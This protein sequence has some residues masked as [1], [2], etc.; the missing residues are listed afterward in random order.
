[1]ARWAARQGRQGKKINRKKSHHTK[2]SIQGDGA[3]AGPVAPRGKGAAMARVIVFGS[4][5][6]DLSMVCGRMPR[7]GETVLGSGF[8]TNPGGKGANQ[9]V[10]A[11]R[12]GATTLMIGRVGDDAF[13]QR[14]TDGL[15]LSGVDCAEVQTESGYAT[16]TAMIVRSEGQNRIIVDPGANHALDAAAA[17]QILQKL[18]QPGDVLLTQLECDLDATFAVIDLA[19]QMGLYTILN[20]APAHELPDSVYGALDLLCVNETEC[21]SLCG[22]YPADRWRAREA[23]DCFTQHGVRNTVI[24]LGKKGSVTLADRRV[25][26]VPAYKVP[27]V[28]STGA[29]DAYLGVLAGRLCDGSSLIEGMRYATAASALAVQ[30]AGAQQSMPTQAQIQEFI[31]VHGLDA[32]EDAAQKEAW[33]QKNLLDDSAQGDDDQS[34]QS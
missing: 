10:A 19:H 23:L 1:M 34:A 22:V 30:K 32:Q 7:A 25:V 12:S 11:A 24:T 33:E 27:A 31:D 14:L 13:G 9:A 21:D 28:D 18:A 29:G 15:L 17:R 6:M 4:L 5:N 3:Q 8:F 2:E 26:R 16:G 20:A